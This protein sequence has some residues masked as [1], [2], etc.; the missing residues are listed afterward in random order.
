MFVMFELLDFEVP[1]KFYVELDNIV[2]DIEVLHLI[3][4]YICI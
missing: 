4:M 3:H 1:T 2:L